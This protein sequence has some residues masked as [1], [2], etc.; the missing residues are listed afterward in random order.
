M[1][2]NTTFG[3]FGDPKTIIVRLWLLTIIKLSLSRASGNLGLGDFG[4]LQGSANLNVP[5]PTDLLFNV[6][7]GVGLLTLINTIAT[8]VTPF[9]MGSADEAADEEAAE[10]RRLQNVDTLKHYVFTGLQNAIARYQ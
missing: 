2:L 7:I 9:L 4:S 5:Q 8:V 1:V 3:T 6:I 10:A